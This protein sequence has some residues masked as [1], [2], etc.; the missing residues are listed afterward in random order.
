MARLK[1]LDPVVKT[2]GAP[3]RRTNGS[4]WASTTE[5]STARGY[6]Y[7]WQKARERVLARDYGLCQPCV[8]ENRATVATEVD[9]IVPKSQGGTDDD[10]N[11]QAICS[12]CH[13][14]KTA[15]D[16]G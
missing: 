6:G 11:L 14:A 5:S 3:A 10:S 4:G 15:R 7:A 9:H 13:K 1:T 12:A 16:R 2:L 8:R